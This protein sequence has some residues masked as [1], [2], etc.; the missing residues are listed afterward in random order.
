[1]RSPTGV[2]ASG[3]ARPRPRSLCSGTVPK[4]FWQSRDGAQVFMQDLHEHPALAA[5]APRGQAGGGPGADSLFSCV[6]AL[7]LQPHL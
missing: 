6:S 3:N 4:S 7:P 2:Y 5:A 1:M